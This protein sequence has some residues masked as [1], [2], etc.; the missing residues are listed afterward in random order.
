M[1]PFSQF[2][3]L[4]W[5]DL[6]IDPHQSPEGLLVLIDGKVHIV[7]H[8]AALYVVGFGIQTERCI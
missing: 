6:E 4:I 5:I 1:A 2:I 7:G 8:K 3:A